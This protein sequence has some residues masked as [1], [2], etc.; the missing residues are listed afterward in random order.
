MGKIKEFLALMFAGASSKEPTVEKLAE[1]AEKL[2]QV[3]SLEALYLG[4]ETFGVENPKGKILG[5]IDNALAFIKAGLQKLLQ[6]IATARQDMAVVVER[7]EKELARITLGRDT[8][9]AY[10]RGLIEGYN[11]R[12]GELD[13]RLAELD[14][15]RDVFVGD[16]EA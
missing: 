11:T 1:V 9:L 15:L 7:F 16:K 13:A 8:Q 12:L 5:I 4:A 10:L 14:K 3:D 6:D 2:P